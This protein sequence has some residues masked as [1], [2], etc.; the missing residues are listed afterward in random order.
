MAEDASWEID[1]QTLELTKLNRVLWPDDGVT[2]GDLLAYYRDIAPVILPHLN[3]RPVTLRSFPGGIDESSHYRREIP[4]GAPEWIRR[5][6]YETATNRHTIELPV[7]EDTAA[8]LWFVNTGAVEL[9]AWPARAPELTEPDQVVFDLDPGDEAEFPMVLEAARALHGALEELRLTGFAKTSGGK[10]LHVYLP[11][12]PGA[13][14]KTVRTWVKAL[15]ERLAAAHPDLIATGGGATHEGGLVTIDYAQNSIGR[16]TAA[17]YTVRARPGAPVSTPVT[18]EEIESG[19]VRPEQW[20]IQTLPAR[21]K[22]VGDLFEGALA[23]S[24][25][26]PPIDD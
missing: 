1:G 20:M 12:A 4:D 26:L 6:P 8:L 10:G 16:N 5:I 21:V 14:F 3:D 23:R 11:L 18:W 7:V 15:A 19:H 17:P 2:K 13:E 9:H 22:K 24:Q 25:T